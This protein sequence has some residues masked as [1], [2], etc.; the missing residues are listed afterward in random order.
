MILYILRHAKAEAQGGLGSKDGDRALTSEGRIKAEKILTLARDSLHMEVD[1][2]LSSPYRRAIET[3]EIA[4][5]ILKPRKPKIV[6][7]EELGPEKS[8]HELYSFV[9]RQKFGPQDRVL[10]V[11]HQPI[12]GETIANLIG[13]SVEIGFPPS[14]LARIDIPGEPQAETGIL[15]WMLSSD[16]L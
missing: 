4:R 10:I 7:G 1:R 8:P 16:V 14:S 15:V 5:D 11:S 6:T 2:I 13:A 12:L 3:S 9:T